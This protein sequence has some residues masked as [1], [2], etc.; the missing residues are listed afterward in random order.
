MRGSP[1]SQNKRVNYWRRSVYTATTLLGLVLVL[2]IASAVI[3]RLDK[4]CYGL[5]DDDVGS[6][7]LRTVSEHA[8]RHGPR[9]FASDIDPMRTR[10]EVIERSDSGKWSEWSYVRVLVS[11]SVTGDDLLIGAVFSDCSIQWLAPDPGTSSP[12]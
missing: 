1:D 2:G 8:E 4:R 9:A 5:S 12:N 7:V 3:S 10:A 11:D 6:Y